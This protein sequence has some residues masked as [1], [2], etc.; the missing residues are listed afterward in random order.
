MVSEHCIKARSQTQE[1]VVLSSSESGFY[2][3]VKAA[4]TMGLGMTGLMADLGLEAKVQV[5]LDSSAAKSIVSRRGAG[6]LRHIEVPELW[7]QD[8]VAK[9][10]LE[11]KKVKG[12]EN[13]ADGLS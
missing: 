6:R 13:V 2:G 4:T 9:G 3:I 1:T 11:I 8:R 7:V 10:Q 5:N 12:E